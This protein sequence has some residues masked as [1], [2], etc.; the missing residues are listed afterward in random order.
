MILNLI[1]LLLGLF[2]FLSVAYFFY[3]K[4]DLLDQPKRY[5]FTRKAVP[6]SFGFVLCVL[7]AL[8]AMAM[9]VLTLKLT[10]LIGACVGLSLMCFVDDFRNLDPV[11]RLCVQFCLATLVVHSGVFLLEVSNPF[12]ANLQLGILSKVVSVFWIVFLTNI[13]NFLDG[14]SGLTSGVSTIAFVTLGVL[15][16]NP[17]IHV[18]D[19]SLL[20]NLSF[21]AA[22]LAFIG[23]V[24][25][26]P[27]P[28]PKVLLGDS[29]SM[30]FGFLLA[31]LSMVNGGKLATLGIVLLIPIFD[32]LFVIFYRLYK[33]KSPVNKDTNHLHHKLLEKGVSRVGIVCIYMILT[34]IFATLAIFSWNSFWKF[35]TLSM[36]LIFMSVFVY[37]TWKPNGSQRGN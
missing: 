21:V 26:I 31:S 13:M 30:F 29:G 6:Y 36:V 24:L 20:V 23:F 10:V 9:N 18:V 22:F 17:S 25:E 11:L 14:V 33:G 32:G 4:F 34:I 12:G 37:L 1:F 16:I 7:F 3:I 27:T 15:A 35:V 8:A 19:Q 2:L 5:G 28:N